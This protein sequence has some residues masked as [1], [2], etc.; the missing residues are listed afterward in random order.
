MKKILIGILIFF[1]TIVACI[2]IAFLTY[3]SSIKRVNNNDEVIRFEVKSGN[4]YY[5]IVD[6]L[7]EKKLIK[8]KLAY[9]IY[10]K[11]NKP[12]KALEAGSYDLKQSMDLKTIINTLSSGSSSSRG[13]TVKVT[14]KEGLNMRQIAKEIHKNFESISTDDLFNLLNDSEYI[15]ELIEKYWF[16]TDD[17]KNGDIYY[18]LEGYLAPNT[19][20]IY[21]DATLKEIIEILLD[22]E[23]KVLNEYKDDILNSK[24]SCHQ[25]LTLASVVELEAKSYDDRKDVAGVFYN[26]LLNNMS[27]GSDVTTYY[28]SKVDMSE[29]DLFIDEINAYNGYNT[30]NSNMAGKLPVGPICNPS[31][32][33]IKAT[34]NY[35]DNEYLYFVSDNKGKVYFARN[36][37]EHLRVINELKEQGLWER[38]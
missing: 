13:E 37:Q 5:T 1:I 20:E 24:Y 16:L 18:S 32:S 30:R 14:F 22:Q 2:L 12:K 21:K 33:S 8:S 25:L 19:Y 34:L 3:S 23:E 26:R 38:Y 27:L 35:N 17:I 4:T 29:R 36:Y 10:L 31:K 9:K 28:A 7:Y 15:D 6:E 11:L